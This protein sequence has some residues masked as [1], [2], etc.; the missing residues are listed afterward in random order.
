M[1][2]ALTRAPGGPLSAASAQTVVDSLQGE[3]VHRGLENVRVTIGRGATDVTIEIEYENRSYEQNEL[4]A[5][6]IVLGLAA[7]RT[8]ASVTLLRAVIKQ[9]NLK[10]LDVTVPAASWLSFVNGGESKA[11][12]ASELRISETVHDA[13]MTELAGTRVAARS[14]FKAD[15]FVRPRVETTLLTEWGVA[16]ARF[17]ALPEAQMQV[18]P[19]TTVDVRGVIPVDRT[20]NF[21]G[22]VDDPFLDRALV[23]QAL[24]VP[25][26]AARAS[27]LTQFSA[28]RY[29]PGVVGAGN[30]VALS[31]AGGILGLK[32]TAVRLGRTF[33]SLDRWVALGSARARYPA[34][35]ATLNVTA[36]KFLDG[37]RG[38][39]G[40]MSRFF[41]N[42]EAGVF[43]RHSGNGTLAGIRFAL[44]LTVRRELPPWRVRP[45]LPDVYSYEQRSTILGDRNEARSDIGRPLSTD[46]E[47]ERIFQDRDRA[48]AAIIRRHVESL[49]AAVRHL[50]D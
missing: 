6:G 40:D 31:L 25:L 20:R 49:R 43:V 16:D 11:A 23:L 12:F 39:S 35:D 38:V 29:L 7:M 26:G 50:L 19:G 37:D 3:L 9:V 24:N 42:T 48:H 5:L 47:V 32:A 44:P 22:T 28:G 18:G 21:P 10:V 8:P 27:L 13:D 15:V 41:G 46:H 4:D 30:E 14:L 17:S 36:G 34:W 2:R 45:R 1:P 33:G